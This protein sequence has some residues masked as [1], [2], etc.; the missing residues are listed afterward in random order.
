MLRL[1]VPC[2]ALAVTYSSVYGCTLGNVSLPHL[3]STCPWK[4]RDLG[5]VHRGDIYAIESADA[6]NHSVFYCFVSCLD[7]VSANCH[8][9]ANP[10][11][12]LCGSQAK[13]SFSFCVCVFKGL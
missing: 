11:L 1:C 7:Q 2:F 10:R 13:A 6:R 3:L 9:R 4:S 5:T 8:S 12:L